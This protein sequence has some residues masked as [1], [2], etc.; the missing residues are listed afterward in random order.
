MYFALSESS[1]TIFLKI[2]LRFVKQF[3]GFDH[4]ELFSW[5]LWFSVYVDQQFPTFFAEKLIRENSVTLEL[6]RIWRTPSDLLR[7]LGVIRTPG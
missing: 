1:Q 7:T 3:P 5:L 6:A 2:P 4:F